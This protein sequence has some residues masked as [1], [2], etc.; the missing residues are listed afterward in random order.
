MRETVEGRAVKIA[1]RRCA[2]F[3]SLGKR[4]G[5][6]KNAKERKKN[7]NGNRKA[8]LLDQTQRIVYDF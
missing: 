8:V 7:G 1:A 3:T 2:C 4:F 6:V 5:F